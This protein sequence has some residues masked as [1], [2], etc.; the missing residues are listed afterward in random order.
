MFVFT[1]QKA[2]D[3]LEEYGNEKKKKV[4]KEWKEVT[5]GENEICRSC[6]S[7]DE[8]RNGHSEDFQ[9]FISLDPL[10][11]CVFHVNTLL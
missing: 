8:E 1:S 9:R 7:A 6:F 3:L 4:R 2:T 11:R 10:C 5:N